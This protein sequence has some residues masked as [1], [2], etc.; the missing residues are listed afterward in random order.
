[1]ARVSSM[2]SASWR[3]SIASANVSGMCILRIASHRLPNVPARKAGTISQPSS[4]GCSVN[5]VWALFL[6]L[7]LLSG[8]AYV[9]TRDGSSWNKTSSPAWAV[10][11]QVPS[12]TAPISEPSDCRHMEMYWNP[13]WGTGIPLRVPGDGKEMPFAWTF[14]E[15]WPD[16]RRAY[17]SPACRA[18]HHSYP[19]S[20]RDHGGRCIRGGGQ[21]VCRTLLYSLRH[22]RLPC[23]I[24]P[25]GY[26]GG[27]DLFVHRHPCSDHRGSGAGW[28]AHLLRK[29]DCT[30]PPV[31]RSG[32]GCRGTRWR[33]T[34]DR[35]QPA[36]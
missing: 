13:V 24:G 22:A 10:R 4:T 3:D 20:R 31:N 1:M 16:R 9:A 34:A 28:Q 23:S 21:A 12:V 25:S 26:Q 5:S 7:Q 17:R 19:V 27:G 8:C 14:V 29:T 35:L 15:D 36:L 6:S 30:R 32:I 33:Q 18:P 11:R 2:V